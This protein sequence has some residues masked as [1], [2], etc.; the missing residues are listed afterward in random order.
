M[1]I[2]RWHIYELMKK[3]WRENHTIM[4]VKEVVAT[5]PGT[6]FEELSEGMIEFQLAHEHTFSKERLLGPDEVFIGTFV[7]IEDSEITK[8]LRI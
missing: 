8:R 7:E 5:Y 3:R 4:T 6:E 1:I 2:N